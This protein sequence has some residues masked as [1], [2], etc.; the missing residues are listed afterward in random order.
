MSDNVQNTSAAD[1]FLKF[2]CRK[3]HEPVA[4]STFVSQDVQNTCV[5]A[6]FVKFRCRTIS[7]V[8]S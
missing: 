7:Q 5:L 3:K 8:A 6:R 1:S 4:A 2:G